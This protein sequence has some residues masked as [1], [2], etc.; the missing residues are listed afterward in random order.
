MFPSLNRFQII[1]QKAFHIVSTESIPRA[2]QRCDDS[3]LEQSIIEHLVISFLV[4]EFDGLPLLLYLHK[5]FWDIVAFLCLH[6]FED[7]ACVNPDLISAKLMVL[8]QIF[9]GIMCSLA[10]VGVNLFSMM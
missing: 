9:P 5:V 1:I 7:V 6:E 8:P 2:W 4:E 3:L 10:V